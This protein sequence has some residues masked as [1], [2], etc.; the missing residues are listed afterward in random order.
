MTTNWHYWNAEGSSVEEVPWVVCLIQRGDPPKQPIA[1]SMPWHPFAVQHNCLSFHLFCC[2]FLCCFMLFPTHLS[3][4]LHTTSFSCSSFVM[5]CLSQ[6]A[7][8]FR[9]LLSLAS[10]VKPR[11]CWG[12]ENVAVTVTSCLLFV[13]IPVLFFFWNWR[14]QSLFPYESNTT[15]LHSSFFWTQLRLSGHNIT[16]LRPLRC[17]NLI[18]HY[19]ALN[20]CIF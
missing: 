16:N 18:C 15:F 5:P 3:T 8:T 13:S 20:L 12:E 2:A 10:F 17:V 6:Y 1:F 7:K 4:V 14:W 11:K 9:N 19:L